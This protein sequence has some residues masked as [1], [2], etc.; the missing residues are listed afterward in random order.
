[1][2][3]IFTPLV[4]VLSARETG[5]LARFLAAVALGL[6]AYLPRFVRLHTAPLVND[7]FGHFQQSEALFR[8]GRLFAKNSI[9]PPAQDFPGLHTLTVGL[10]ELSGISTITLGVVLVAAFHVLAILGIYCLASSL[11]DDRRVGGLAASL[12]AV[13]P[14]FGFFDSMYAYE[15]FAIPLL[16]W[17]LVCA[18]HLIEAR[19]S[20][21]RRYWVVALV[22]VAAAAI[23][24]H[25]L[26]SYVVVI[27]LIVLTLTHRW[28]RSA[29][30]VTTARS[31]WMLGLVALC[32]AALAG[33]RIVNSETDLVAY[34]SVFPR[35]GVE[36][37]IEIFR[38]SADGGTRPTGSAPS[39]APVRALFQGSALPGYE[40][41]VAYLVPPVLL[42]L[43]GIGVWTQR[44]L[45][46]ARTV[47]VSVL[48]LA[49]FAS[50]PFVL[51]SGGSPGAHRSWAYSYVGLSVIAGLGL[52]RLAA[53]LPRLLS[54]MM[55]P[56]VIVAVL[57]GN[58]GSAVPDAERFPGPYQLGRDGRSVTQELVEMAKWFGVH[59]G[60]GQQ[61]VTD[62]RTAA[63]M[64]AYAEVTLPRFP[65][66]EL[67]FPTAP[68]RSQFVDLMYER[69]IRYVVVNRRLATDRYYSVPYFHDQPPPPSNPLPSSSIAKFDEL[70][71]LTL[72]Y[73]S[74]N[75]R[76][77]RTV[78]REIGEGE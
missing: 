37:L 31:G 62:L 22:I 28:G 15:S 13:S 12:Y 2:A 54:R 70:S 17:S 33:W 72:I 9:V 71:W 50:L 36:A 55:C 49:Y 46:T 44:S 73:E 5:R 57:M 63:P 41:Y 64:V 7:E 45:L 23:T 18:T 51:T 59:E 1:M 40:R 27:S 76:I 61:I 20:A 10:R 16:I 75:F 3:S 69:G 25:H 52:S 60:R 11:G 58:Y 6:A 24:T 68:P 53:R 8:T 67:F 65:S 34:L 77:Y 26:T 74:T 43:A 19:R 35:R 48:G 30:V 42:L 56:L 38:S 14:S 66:W 47:A 4:L 21:D 32:L 39:S 78:D 29:W